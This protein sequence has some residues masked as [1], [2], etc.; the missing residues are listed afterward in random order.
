[1]TA[2]NGHWRA[3]ILEVVFRFL[4]FRLDLPGDIGQAMLDVSEQDLRKLCCEIVDTQQSL[5][6]RRVHRMCAEIQLLLL[7]GLLDRNAI[8]DVLLRPVLD[9]DEA[10][11]QVH[12]FS[13]DHPLSI[14]SLVH[15]INFR[16]NSNRSYTLWVDLAGHLQAIGCC[17]ISVRW[18][19]A[20]NNGP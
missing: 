3:K 2:F 12:I 4:D 18:Q 10:K 9:S 13:F 8:D 5:R 14:R 17:H 11:T 15:N 6:H 7:D 19:R 16:D 1:M 20:K